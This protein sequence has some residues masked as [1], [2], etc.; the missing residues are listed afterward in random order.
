MNSRIQELVSKLE[1]LPHPEGGFFKELYRSEEEIV[2]INIGEKRSLST[3]ILFLITKGN[4]SHFHSI[5]SDEIWYFNE[6]APLKVHCYNEERG[7]WCQKIGLDIANGELPQ[8]T[9]PK[10]TIFGSETDGDYSLVSCMVSPGFD[11]RDFNLYTTSEMQSKKSHIP[12]EIL[13]RLTKESYE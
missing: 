2:P 9:V 5:A 3:S 1:L 11:F 6:G 8:Y 10:G 12:Q 13:F 4:A 7:Y